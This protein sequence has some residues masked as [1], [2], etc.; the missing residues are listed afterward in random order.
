[1]VNGPIKGVRV[2]LEELKKTPKLVLWGRAVRSDGSIFPHIK[3][4]EVPLARNLELIEKNG[5]LC[6]VYFTFE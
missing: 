4:L 2:D 6:D 1:M 5:L 3:L